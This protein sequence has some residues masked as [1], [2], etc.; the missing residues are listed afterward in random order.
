MR[1][2]VSSTTTTAGAGASATGD[3]GTVYTGF[4]GTSSSSSSKKSAGK[5]VLDAG[6]S[7]GLAVVLAGL[8][9]GFALL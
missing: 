9:A 6:A 4:G 5:M 1:V 8:F 2:N 7:Y 3:S